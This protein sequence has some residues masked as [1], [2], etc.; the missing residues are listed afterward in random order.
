MNVGV[1]ILDPL[2]G[3]PGSPFTASPSSTPNTSRPGSPKLALRSTSPEP[4]FHAPAGRV[5]VQ[6]LSEH[7][8]LAREAAFELLQARAPK[9]A[10]LLEQ[11]TE[12]A[13]SF[14]AVSS[15]R[16][17]NTPGRG[18]NS[19]EDEAEKAARKRYEASNMRRAEREAARQ[20][21]DKQLALIKR[22]SPPPADP[23][24]VK[25]PTPVRPRVSPARAHPW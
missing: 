4:L 21:R 24:L 20:S 10:Q 8:K 23:L 17:A 1:P 3:P 9:S 18:R 7:T 14:V 13:V 5:M 22:T 25:R 2:S 12:Q 15:G 16:R 6:E 19:V 11:R